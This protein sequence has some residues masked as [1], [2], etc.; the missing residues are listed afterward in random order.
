MG[1]IDSLIL[2]DFNLS[3]LE[4]WISMELLRQN[5]KEKYPR[6]CFKLLYRASKHGFAASAFHRRCDHK[7]NTLVVISANDTIFGGFTCIPWES[8]NVGRA[9]DQIIVARK[10]ANTFAFFWNRRVQFGKASTNWTNRRNGTIADRIGARMQRTHAIPCIITWHLAPSLV[11]GHALI[12]TAISALT[13]LS[14]T[15]ATKKLNS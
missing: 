7:K 15:D 9:V 5:R 2:S 4:S 14:A 10:S 6:L 12:M 11:I 13:L 1:K 3:V 8:A